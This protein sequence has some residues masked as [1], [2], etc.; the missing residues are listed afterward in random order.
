M[1][2]KFNRATPTTLRVNNS[3]EGQTI[4]QFVRKIMKAGEPIGESTTGIYYAENDGVPFEVNVR[5]DRFD[6]ALEIKEQGEREAVAR[7]TGT[8]APAEDVE[9]SEGGE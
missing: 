8:A 5:T 9:T 2:Y 6:K 1:A 3:Y 4:E 7:V